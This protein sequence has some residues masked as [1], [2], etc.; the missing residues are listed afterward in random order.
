MSR[1]EERKGEKTATLGKV[2]GGEKKT[3]VEEIFIYINGKGCKG[4][5]DDGDKSAKTMVQ[6]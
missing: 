6:R 3:S 5:V 1:G 2:K 4:S